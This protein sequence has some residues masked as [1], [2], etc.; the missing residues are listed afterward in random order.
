M[1]KNSFMKK[2]TAFILVGTFLFL[3][4]CQGKLSDKFDEEEVKNAAKDIV[5]QVNEGN[6]ESVYNDI[7]SP[8]MTNAIALD[9]LQENL[10]YTL[11]KVG[12]FESFEKI[13]VAGTKDKDTGT[14]YATVMVLA[15]YEEGNAMFTI[16]FDEDM[17][18]AG[19]FIK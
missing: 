17:E 18:C 9:T 10:S 13:E 3:T 8:V 12:D 19:F 16:S 6:V 7:F 15:K 1:R 2:L 11:E 4:G 14:E 5:T